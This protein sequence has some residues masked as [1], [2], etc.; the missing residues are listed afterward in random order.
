MKKKWL[1]V[2]ACA[3]LCLLIVVGCGGD[4]G[5]LAG[6][7]WE[8]SKAEAGGVT[9]DKDTIESQLGGASIAFK[10]DKEYTLNG[11]GSPASGTYKVDGD[12]IQLEDKSGTVEAEYDG[13]QIV[14]ET[15]GT[16]MFFTKKE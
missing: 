5:S 14:I 11:L 12:S 6:T 2:L 8:L 9:V 3:M 4:K 15:G 1:A 7:T 16:K 13:S 10:S